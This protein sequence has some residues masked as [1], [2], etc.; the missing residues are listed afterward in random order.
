VLVAV[1]AAATAASAE[2]VTPFYTVVAVG[3]WHGIIASD[4]ERRAVPASVFGAIDLAPD[5]PSFVVAKGAESIWI[6]SL[7]YGGRTVPT[8]GRTSSP[9]FGP[10]DV[11]AYG[12]GTKLRVVGGRTFRLPGTVVEVAAAE[13][14]FA[15][16]V[17]LGN[18]AKGTLKSRLYLVAHGHARALVSGFDPYAAL[19]SP[20][21]S[22]DGTM[23]AYTKGGDVWVV[24]RDGIKQQISHTKIAVERGPRWSPDST[25]L[26]Y[27]TTRHGVNEVYAATLDGVERRLT[28][29]K[30]RPARVPQ[31]GSTMGAWSP[32]GDSVAVVNYTSVGVVPATGGDEHIVR[33][34]MPAA[35]AYVGPIWWSAAY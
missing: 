28:H 11:V 2:N 21:F 10:G 5:E 16:T 18:A 20:Q 13:D 3:K 27:T 14:A 22:P 35:S 9:V 32:D 8:P 23:I 15:A 29:T 33:T 25:Q 4:G 12:A 7:A 1:L 34:F 6:G 19:P 30:P 26:A 24:D 31:T 17:E